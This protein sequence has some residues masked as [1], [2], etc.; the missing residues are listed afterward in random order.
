MVTVRL[1]TRTDVAEVTRLS[2][3][4]GYEENEEACARRFEQLQG[5]QEH[6][7]FVAEM[8]TAKLGGWIHLCEQYALESEPFVEI[9]GLVV[10]ASRRR[11]SVGK[12]LV[13]A[14]ESWA[15][16]LGF[17]RLRV[18]SNVSRVEAHLFYPS[19]GF[20]L[21]KTQTVYEQRLMQGT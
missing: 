19:L 8:A 10:D 13:S 7:L 14:G 1:M 20:V 6:A 18:R 5:R 15:R 16:G 3:V 2:A 4:L 17:Q 21:Q 9:K 12:A 11:A